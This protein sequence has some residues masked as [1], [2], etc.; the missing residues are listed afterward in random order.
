MKLRNTMIEQAYERELIAS[1]NALFSSD[2]CRPIL[3]ALRQ[4]CGDVKVAF[5][6][7]HTPE[8]GEDLFRIFVNG[9]KI[10]GFT[11]PKGSADGKIED[12]VILNVSEYRKLLRGRPALI[13]LEAAINLTKLDMK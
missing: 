3:D 9:E 1:R 7:C 5:I 4:I 2:N 12:V 13:Q 11:L 6:L 10:I 8:Q